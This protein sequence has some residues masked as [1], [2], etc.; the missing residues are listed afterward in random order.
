MTDAVRA[1]VLAGGELPP[2]AALPSLLTVERDLLVAAD[3]GLD[4]ALALG[5]RVDLVVGDLDSASAGA[6]AQAREA[7]VGFETHPTTKDA[8]DLELALHAARVRGATEI[9]VIG[10]GGGRHD[11]LLANALLLG[12]DAF[13]D[14]ALDAYVGIAHLVVIRRRATLRGQPGDLCS[15]VPLGGTATR[16]HTTGLRYPLADEDLTA[17]S[18]RGVSN[19]LLADRA[20]VEIAA[21]VLL[22]ILPFALQ[23]TN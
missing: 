13:A 9:T 4:H 16:V 3:S 7:G 21:G 11:H 10:G 19:E 23:E 1:V 20:T 5:A 15:L 22:A 2:L 18:T 8:T 14:L 17:G 12:A 6:Q